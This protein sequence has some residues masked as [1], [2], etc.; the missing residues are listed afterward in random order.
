MS[1][2]CIF[3]ES[4]LENANKR[5]GGIITLLGVSGI[6]FVIADVSFLPGEK[7]C[8]VGLGLEMDLLHRPKRAN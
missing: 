8:G 6:D 7:I 2:D 5:R 3:Q 4:N 1:T